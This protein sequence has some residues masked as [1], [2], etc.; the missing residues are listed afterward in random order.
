MEKF[1]DEVFF[2]GITGLLSNSRWFYMIEYGKV[3]LKVVRIYVKVKNIVN[4]LIHV[5]FSV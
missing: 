3:S 1:E 2:I 4:K 5:Q